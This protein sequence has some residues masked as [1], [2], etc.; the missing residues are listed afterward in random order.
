MWAFTCVPRPSTNRPP[1]SSARSQAACAVTIGLRG[2][3]TAISVP[4]VTDVVV[5]A[6]RADAMYGLCDDSVNQRPEKPAA[7][8][9][10]ATVPTADG[11]GPCSTGRAA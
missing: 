6:A 8:T 10:V 11:R 1:V 5:R 2:N 4:I 9:A 7:S 3:A